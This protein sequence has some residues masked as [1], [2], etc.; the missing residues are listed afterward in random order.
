[1]KKLISI[2][3]II[4]G[5]LQ[6][7]CAQWVQQTSGVTTSLYNIQFV[8]LNTGWA[9]GSNSVIL[10]TTNGGVNW[11]QQTIDLGYPKNLYGLCMVN[12]F[13]GYVAGWFETILKTTNGG[14]N[15]VII[16]NIPSNNGNSNNSVSF[17]NAQTGWICAFLGRVLRTSNGGISW[18]TANIG[19]TGPLR[20]IQFLDSQTGWVCGD[21]GNLK[22]STNGGMNWVNT[23]TLLTT[24]N[25]LSL[26]FINANTGWTASEQDRRVFRTTNAGTKWD[27]LAV[28]PG[29]S[30]DFL[31]S[32]YFVNALTGW[33]GGSNT[34]LFKS[35]D[36][37][38]NWIQQYLPAPMYVWNL[39]FYNDSVGWATGGNDGIIVHT[40]TG[41][42]YVGIDPVSNT[43][44]EN[45]KLYQNYPNPFNPETVIEFDIPKNGIY[46]IEIYDII[47]RSICKLLNGYKETGKYKINYNAESLSSGTYFYV[48]SSSKFREVRKMILTK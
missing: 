8:N 10:K 35:T 4:H 32:V 9:T 19:N 1:M 34:L 15:W 38:V 3:L 41:G 14:D 30:V 7:T 16:S 17:I 47:G 13:T 18:D 23:S 6:I 21:V 42:T 11:F 27:T 26:H 22:K 29:G 33:T 37:G 48:L 43:I 12:E 28:L 39:S 20:D 24:A 46:T 45:F 36:G 2:I 31:Y 44:P 25:L 40:T 5:S